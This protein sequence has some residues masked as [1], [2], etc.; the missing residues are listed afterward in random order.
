MIVPDQIN[1]NKSVTM[2]WKCSKRGHKMDISWVKLNVF[3]I[4][5]MNKMHSL[6]TYIL[7]LNLGGHAPSQKAAKIWWRNPIPLLK[8]SSDSSCIQ[9]HFIIFMW[10]RLLGWWDIIRTLKCF[11]RCR[12]LKAAFITKLFIYILWTVFV[13]QMFCV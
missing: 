9:G 10:N 12:V 1:T 8:K 4:F 3:I 11:L 2:G 5:L 6:Y 7:K 13:H